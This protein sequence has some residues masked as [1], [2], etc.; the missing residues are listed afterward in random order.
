MKAKYIFEI[1][2]EISKTKK[3]NDKIKRAAGADGTLEDTFD[4]RVDPVFSLVRH[5]RYADVERRLQDNFSPDA[6]SADGYNNSLMMIAAQNGSKRM[7]ILKN[8]QVPTLPT[9][10][11]VPTVQTVPTVPTVRTVRPVRTVPTAPTAPTVPT[12][13]T[14]PTVQPSELLRSGANRRSMLLP[15][16]GSVFFGR[17]T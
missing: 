3:K 4:A 15:G 1:L 2:Q 16:D 14:A 5:G 12:A 9:V 7:V 6:P 11:T 8:N 10:P 13:P 17:R